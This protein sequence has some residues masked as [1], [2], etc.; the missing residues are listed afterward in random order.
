ML[1]RDID[2]LRTSREEVEK[3]LAEV[4]ADEPA[5]GSVLYIEEL[6]IDISSN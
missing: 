1:S 5:F 6:A 4:V 3:L 2:E